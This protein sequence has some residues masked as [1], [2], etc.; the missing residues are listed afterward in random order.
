MRE[1]I[2]QDLYSRGASVS[3]TRNAVQETWQYK[4]RRLQSWVDCPVQPAFY[5]VEHDEEPTRKTGM[6]AKLVLEAKWV[7]YQN[8]GKDTSAV[9]S[10]LNN[11]IMD[12]FDL[13][14]QDLAGSPH[15]FRQS[16]GGLV[17]SAY[18]DGKVFRDAGD[19][20]G[21]GVIVLPIKIIVP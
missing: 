19:L 1:E 16:L 3:W 7:V 8:L 11:L 4:S 9:P 20:D 21:Q 18:I 15:D 13:V 6:P 14:F 10:I 17:Y 2:F 5:Q 12:Q